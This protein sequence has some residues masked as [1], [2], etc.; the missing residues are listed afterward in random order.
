[1]STR[2]MAALFCVALAAATAS[3][4]DTSEPTFVFLRPQT[5]SFWH[6]ATNSTVTLPIVFPLGAA[7]ANLSVRGV[8]YSRDF[9]D[10]SGPEFVLSL[11]PPT[12]PDKE[13]V[14]ELTLAFDNGVTRTAKLGVV[15]GV[16]TG[17]EGWTRCMSA[18][19][20]KEWCEVLKRAV[21]PIPYGMTSFSVDGDQVDTGLNGEQGWCAVGRIGSGQTLD[22]SMTVDG[23]EYDV[24]LFGSPYGM[25]LIFK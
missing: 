21:L 3:A 14:Y 18:V 17:D 24:S 10:I 8:R 2:S 9:T 15:Q 22:L 23:V 11:P 6:T 25:T 7:S 13:N 20:S 16:T 5:S 4:A 19:S 12:S 1:M